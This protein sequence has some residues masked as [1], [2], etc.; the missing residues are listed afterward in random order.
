MRTTEDAPRGRFDL[1][2]RVH[3]LADL[4]ECGAVSLVECR[5]VTPPHRERNFMRVPEDAVVGGKKTI[6]KTGFQKKDYRAT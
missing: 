3:S 6:S 4:I 5:R 2:D 1:L